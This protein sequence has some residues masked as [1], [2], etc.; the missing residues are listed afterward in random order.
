MFIRQTNDRSSTLTITRKILILCPQTPL[1]RDRLMV[2][3]RPLKPFI[4]VRIQV[5]EPRKSLSEKRGFLLLAHVAG[6]C[7]AAILIL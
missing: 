4:L 3:H 5:P 2:G 7:I 6:P 1:F